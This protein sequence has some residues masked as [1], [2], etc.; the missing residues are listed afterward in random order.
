MSTDSQSS[1][2][3]RAAGALL[4]G[5]AFLAVLAMLHHPSS[6]HGGPSLGGGL[7]LGQLVHGI[8]LVVLTAQVWAMIVY[9]RTRGLGG[10]VLPALVAYGVNLVAHLIAAT[11]NGFVVPALAVRLD[12]AA[13][14]DIFQLLWHTNQSF[15][16]IGVHATGLAFVFW[17]VDLLAR[18]PRAPLL[19]L[20]GLAAGLVPSIA[21]LSGHLG[22]N[23]SGA[24]LVYSVHM[25]WLAA[26]G[27]RLV[28]PRQG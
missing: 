7:S 26:I 10:W 23:V 2:E 17:S 25:V 1:T 4:L 14:H 27:V 16:Q 22:M 8:M 11:V 5:S 19:G 18:S 9:S 13:S 15:A 20:A 6:A 28:Q 12:S 21:L 24:L 3:R